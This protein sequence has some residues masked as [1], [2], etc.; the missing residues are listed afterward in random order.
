[1]FNLEHRA[2]T[3]D[4]NLSFYIRGSNRSKWILTSN[5]KSKAIV[6]SGANDA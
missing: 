5:N 4:E 3:N 2:S 1:M 6:E